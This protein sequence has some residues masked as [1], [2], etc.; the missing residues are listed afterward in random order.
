MEISA[1]FYTSLPVK[2]QGLGIGFGLSSEA[3]KGVRLSAVVASIVMPEPVLTGAI[4]RVLVVDD[5]RAQR[6][7][8]TRSLTRQGYEVFEAASGEE[9][10]VACKA[11]QFDLI[12]SDWMMPGMDGIEFCQAFRALPRENYGYFIL[13]TSKTE[14]GAVAQGLDVGADDF[15]TKPVKRDELLAR[16]NAGDRILQMERELAEKNRLV[17]A[18][19]AEIQ[20]LY[21]S[22]D[23][24]LIDARKMQQSLVREPFRDLGT[25]EVSLL[26]K[27]CGHVGGDL[28]GFFSA[29]KNRLGFYSIDVSGHGVASAMLTARLASYLSEGAPEQNIA[30]VRDSDGNYLA[31]PPSE[32][33][34]LLNIL[35][36]EDMETDL[37]FTILIGFL[38]LTTGKVDFSQCGHPC[39]LILGANGKVR[40]FGQGGLPIGLI[41]DADFEQETVQLEP[42]D[43]LLFYSDGFTECENDNG[44][45][46]DEDGF[47]KLIVENA[48]LDG[49]DFFTALIWDL[50]LYSGSLDF[51]DDLS[52]TMVR[53]KGSKSQN[54][55]E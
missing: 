42:G 17:T 20:T 38:D 25:A 15:L 18:T 13:L 36:I 27:P 19:L 14:K 40:F 49:G 28:P 29:G 2:A 9:A 8:L 44:D 53:Y 34:D 50:D 33:A 30:L 54:S 5:S 55:L 7:L 48:E 21:D 10:L 6:M 3:T 51:G 41:P 31:R 37:Y 22:L 26:L 4:R 24:D 45:Q 43:R 52:C 35:M 12:L 39:P 32:V 46:L 16:I 23:R 47:E 11:D 1:Q